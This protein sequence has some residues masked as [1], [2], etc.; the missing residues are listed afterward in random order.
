MGMIKSVA[1]KGV[2]GSLVG[3][4]VGKDDK[5]E[6]S[7]L[8]YSQ[9]DM[10]RSKRKRKQATAPTKRTATALSGGEPLG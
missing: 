4:L 5:K 3:D 1:T 10:D 7:L 6:G 8:K 9:R 2:L